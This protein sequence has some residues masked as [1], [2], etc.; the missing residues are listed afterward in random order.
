MTRNKGIK[1][2][3]SL[4]FG[5]NKRQIIIMGI[6]VLICLVFSVLTGGTFITPRNLSNLC[7]QASAT[8]IVAIG[9]VLVLVYG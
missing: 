7:L 3:F 2:L 1:Y 4:E 6:F 8:G 9:L 5:K